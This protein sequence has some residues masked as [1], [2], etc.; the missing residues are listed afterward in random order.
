MDQKFH[1]LL[2]GGTVKYRLNWPRG[3][4]TCKGQ[5]KKQLWRDD[6]SPSGKKMQ[7]GAIPVSRNSSPKGLN[8][9]RARSASVPIRTLLREQQKA[10][11]NKKDAMQN[12]VRKGERFDSLQSD[13]ACNLDFTIKSITPTITSKAIKL[14][15]RKLSENYTSRSQR[16]KLMPECFTINGRSYGA[17]LHHKFDIQRCKQLAKLYKCELDMHRG[18]DGSVF[19]RAEEPKFTI[20]A[21]PA[22]FHDNKTR[23]TSGKR[24]IVIRE[25]LITAK[26]TLKIP[27]ASTCENGESE[28]Y[29]PGLYNIC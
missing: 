26:V 24:K 27:K 14:C 6:L 23:L 11:L 17:L 22:V 28:R 16:T 18:K 4:D 19:G 7:R 1:N 2:D 9:N 20:D 21:R 13:L 12:G 3:S 29:T 15:T 10:G 25:G 8:K 5:E